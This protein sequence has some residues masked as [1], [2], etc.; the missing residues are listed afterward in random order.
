MLGAH[1]RT[2]FVPLTNLTR[3]SQAERKLQGNLNQRTLVDTVRKDHVISSEKLTT[4]FLGAYTHADLVHTL[5]V[6]A[7]SSFLL[8]FVRAAYCPKF[9]VKEVHFMSLLRSAHFMSLLRSAHFMSLLRSAHFMS[10]L[11][12]AHFMSLLR[13]AHV[14]SLLRSAHFMSLLRSAF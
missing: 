2:S 10:L 6:Y 1:A 9:A 14:M 3:V 13:S 4:V 12:S 7:L 5:T 11:R 8:D